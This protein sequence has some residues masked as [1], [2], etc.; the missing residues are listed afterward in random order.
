MFDHV[1]V[2]GVTKVYGRQRALGGVSLRLEAGR[3]CALLGPN[4]AGKSTLLGILSTLLRPTGGE[5]RFGSVQH[6]QAG[7]TLRGAIGLVAHESFLY[8]DLTGREN[9]RFFERL[10]GG[11][12]RAQTLLSRVGLDEAA[13]RPVRTYSRGMQQRLALARA[14]CGQPRLLLLDEPFT[15]LDSS[16]V[17]ALRTL[18]AELRDGGVIL[19]LV[20]HDLA[21]AAELANHVV[22]LRRG[23]VAFDHAQSAPF[24]RLD[25]VYAAHA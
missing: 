7:R 18:L 5:V 12:G 11:G 1:T 15:G 16:G 21:A 3:L 22:V 10:Y 23:K 6:R 24:A 14:L 8:G 19:M 2:E 4:G 13:D 20:T 25:E 17:A 9:L